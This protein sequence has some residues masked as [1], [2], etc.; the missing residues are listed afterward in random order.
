MRFWEFGP[1]YVRSFE[2]K[3][4]REL[5]RVRGQKCIGIGV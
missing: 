3:K 4:D 5:A 2:E 1:G